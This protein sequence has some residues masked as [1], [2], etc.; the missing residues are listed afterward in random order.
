[1]LFVYLKSGRS[2]ELPSASTAK[3]REDNLICL[4][5]GGAEIAS[6]RRD[7]V[8]NFSKR[9]LRSLL[10]E[11]RASDDTELKQVG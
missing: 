8:S 5:D 11:E 6:F 3:F 9:D 4:D 2:V 10:G 1:M 7:E